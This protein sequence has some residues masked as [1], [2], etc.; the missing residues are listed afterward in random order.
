MGNSNFSLVQVQLREQRE[1]C[2][3][4]LELAAVYKNMDFTTTIPFYLTNVYWSQRTFYNNGGISRAKTTEKQ[5]RQFRT[6]SSSNC[7]KKLKIVILRLPCWSALLLK[8]IW[9]LKCNITFSSLKCT[10]QFNRENNVRFTLYLQSFK[11]I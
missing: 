5:K 10:L 11:C 4:P 1:T 6:N 2:K 7:T 8:R 9:H 3:I